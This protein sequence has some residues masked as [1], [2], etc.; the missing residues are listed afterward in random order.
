MSGSRR[1][2]GCHSGRGFGNEGQGRRKAAEWKRWRGFASSEFLGSLTEGR[3]EPGICFPER[4]S[5]VLLD[6]VKQGR[7]RLLWL[8]GPVERILGEMALGPSGLSLFSSRSRWAALSISW[9][10]CAILE[11]YDSGIRCFQL[12][13]GLRMTVSVTAYFSPRSP[14]AAAVRCIR[15]CGRTRSPPPEHR[16][17]TALRNERRVLERSQ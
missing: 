8:L 1:S 10:S 6:G 11:R 16:S 15:W 17:A 9:T 7:W 5:D 3:H 12:G 13:K 4:L 2:Q 14:R